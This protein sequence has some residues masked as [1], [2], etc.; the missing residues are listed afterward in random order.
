MK[1][2]RY[3]PLVFALCSA[4]AWADTPINLSHPAAAD[5]RL[6]VSNVKGAVRITAWDRNEV[7]VSGRL[8]DGAKPL[9]ITGTDGSLSI[10]V[11]PEGRSG[12]FGWGGDNAMSPTTLEL[13]VPRGASLDLGVVS[14][15]INVEGLRGGSIEADAVSGRVQI[16]AQTPSLQVQSVS[17]NIELAGH[18]D[19]A[20]LQ[21]VSG[22]I[23][24]PSLG[25]R[26]ELQTV[27]G[28]I[29]A[30]GG[31][32]EKVDLST[33]SGDVQL[34]GGLAPAGSI[35]IDSM[36]GNVQLKL[37][38]SVSAH[39]E[40]SSFSGDLRSDFGTPSRHEHGPGTE[41]DTRTGNGN[42]NIH[43][44]SFSGDLRISKSD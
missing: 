2:Y 41:L 43:A 12:L 39:I 27:S 3:L 34:G 15:S 25:R 40:A 16:E 8:G 1:R 35:D 30:N 9:T 22:D 17:G 37:P 29:R 4:A 44:E 19:T 14:A 23:L 6:Q 5:V 20:E 31:P 21:T 26:A 42:G 32:W 38:A 11:E 7:R 13:N 36:S 10:K 24:A 28:R 18:A 33:V